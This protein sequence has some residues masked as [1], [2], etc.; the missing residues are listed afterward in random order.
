M[1]NG[2][3]GDSGGIG[4][5]GRGQR[6]QP[7]TALRAGFSAA[8]TMMNA[9]K[10]QGD[11][12]QMSQVFDTGL[13]E[14]RQYRAEAAQVDIARSAANKARDTVMSKSPLG[15]DEI[16]GKRSAKKAVDSVKKV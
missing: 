12:G 9:A 1:G 16:L 15:K 4:G 3:V 7:S 8:R 2:E 14:L 6:P 10:F 5:G 13:D 11:P